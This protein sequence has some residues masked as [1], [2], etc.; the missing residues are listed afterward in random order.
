ADDLA[1]RAAVHPAL[2]RLEVGVL[3]E[4]HVLAGRPEAARREPRALAAL[5]L[6]GRLLVH[7]EPAGGRDRSGGGLRD[8]DPAERP[9]GA[10]DGS[11]A[12]AREGLG[13]APGVEREQEVV[14]AAAEEL[15]VREDHGR[16]EEREEPRAVLRALRAAREDDDEEGER[17][18][19]VA[20]HL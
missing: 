4:R 16:E 1:S 8:V 12:S 14:L 2:A 11:G 13:G 19:E 9:L 5:L 6:R 3:E 15:H 18:D 20:R 17:G 7:E 10:G